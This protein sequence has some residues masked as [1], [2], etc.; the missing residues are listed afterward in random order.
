MKEIEMF[1]RNVWLTVYVKAMEVVPQ[2]RALA[3]RECSDRAER[4]VESYRKM[5]GDSR[6]T[7]EERD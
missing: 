5:F 3:H 2:S 7:E 4:A 1:D 6:F